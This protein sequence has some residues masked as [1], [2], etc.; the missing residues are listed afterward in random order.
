MSAAKIAIKLQMLQQ[1]T[2][3]I[4]T[5][6]KALIDFTG[7]INTVHSAMPNA[8]FT[9]AGLTTRYRTKSL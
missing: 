5:P 8:A 4:A 9:H 1:A 2:A 3:Y 6:H 7:L